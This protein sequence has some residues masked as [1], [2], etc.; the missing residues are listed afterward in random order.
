MLRYL[1]RRVLFM[2]LVLLMVSLLTFLIFV[3]LPAGDPARRATGKTSTPEQIE[4]ARRAFGL[5]R[6]LY[7]QYARFAKG[8]IPWPGLFLSEDVYYSYGNFV[9]VKEEIARRL[10]VTATLAVGA[11]TV[12]LLIGIPV[13][14]LAGVKRR[15]PAS[16]LAMFLAI[17][18]VSMPVF[19]LGQLLLYVF[20][21]QLGWAPSSGLEIGESVPAAILSGSFILPWITVAI[22]YAAIY[23]RM[24]RS[25]VIETMSE[26]YIRTARAKGLPERTVIGR[27]GLRGALTPIVTMLGLDLGTLLGGL[28]ITEA[29]FGLPGIGSLAV[30]SIARQD[31]PMVMGVTVLGALFIAIANLIVDV[32]YAALDPRVRYT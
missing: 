2:V 18:G 9:A 30:D 6:P 22:G 26:D 7:V 5:D 4:N 29:L 28:F 1:V 12:W 13:G 21:F 31:F 19:W 8:L 17:V 20:W 3:K 32:A 23:A 10:P 25:N 27:H 11:A 14:V 16:R 24:T 15:S